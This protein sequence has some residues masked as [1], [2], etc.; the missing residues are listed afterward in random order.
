MAP[1]QWART[2]S[3]QPWSNA[4]ADGFVRDDN[5][6]YQVNDKQGK[7]IYGAAMADN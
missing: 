7:N 5:Q 2:G 4:S 3:Q 6:G 1:T